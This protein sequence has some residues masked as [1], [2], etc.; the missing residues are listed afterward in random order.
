MNKS[1]LLLSALFIS[2]AVH[3]QTSVTT[4]QYKTMMQPALTLELANN[5]EDVKATILQKLKDAGYKPQTEGHLF[6]K[7]NTTDGFYVFNNTQLPSL[8]SQK[9]DM[10]F[11][12]TQKNKEEKNNSLIYLLISTGN[13]NFTSPEQDTVLWDNARVFLNSLIE[14]T[15]AYSLEEDIRKQ[16]DVLAASRKKLSNFQ[17]DEKDM[18]GKMKKMQDDLRTNKDNQTNQQLEVENQRQAL[19][20]LKLKRKA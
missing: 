5:Q 18:D 13:E 14:N 16:E 11:K 1:N 10:Y 6:W 17:K 20:A 7:N 2:A 19:E 15:T 12:I 3:S 8:G 9:L 4:V